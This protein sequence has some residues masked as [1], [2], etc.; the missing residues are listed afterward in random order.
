[1][2]G[3]VW[4]GSFV[5]VAVLGVVLARYDQTRRRRAQTDRCRCPQHDA[6]GTCATDGAR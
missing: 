5:L 3:F 4:G 2:S 1:M 6:G